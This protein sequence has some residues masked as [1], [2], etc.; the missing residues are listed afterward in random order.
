MNSAPSIAARPVSAIGFARAA[1]AS[2]IAWP[3][4]TPR[5]TCRLTKSTS[6]IELRTMMP[7][8]AII[9]II[10]VAVNGCP[11]SAWPGITP[12][13]VSGIGAMMTSGVT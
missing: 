7:A 11:R 4:G 10:D 3:K 6:R 1:A 13:M 12:M 8:S 2:T 9:P 5:A